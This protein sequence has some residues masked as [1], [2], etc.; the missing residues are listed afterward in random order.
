M[1][2]ITLPVYPLAGAIVSMI[3]T[4]YTVSNDN[5]LGAYLIAFSGLFTYFLLYGFF[6]MIGIL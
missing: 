4:G 3:I 5:I 1:P 6:A 2:M